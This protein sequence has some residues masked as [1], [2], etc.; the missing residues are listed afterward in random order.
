D[1]LS[2][3]QPLGAGYPAIRDGINQ[4]WDFGAGTSNNR[5]A[6]ATNNG[7]WPNL[8]KANRVDTDQVAQGQSASIKLY[9]QWA[10][11]NT[12]NAT[13]S[14]YLDN[15]LNPFTANQKLLKQVNFPG[16][17]A[18]G[19]TNATISLP[20]AI[21]NASPGWHSLLAT[22]KA[23]NQTRYLYTPELIQVM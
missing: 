16:T 7:T 2:S 12:N 19:V 9:Y 11:G 8:I 4:W 22:V 18:G 21:S 14:F 10:R 23:G 3:D 5:T 1:R 13:V 6:L 20:L 17:G 15:D